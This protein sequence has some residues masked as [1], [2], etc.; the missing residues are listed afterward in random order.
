MGLL[1]QA[2]PLASPVK[3]MKGAMTMTGTIKS[4]AAS[5]ALISLA[6]GGAVKAAEQDMTVRARP[7]SA[8]SF[9][10]GS[11]HATGYFLVRDGSCD[12]SVWLADK[13]SGDE[14]AIGTPA[15]MTIPVSPGSTMFVSSAEGTAAEF[16]CAPNADFMSVRI[17]TEVA[18]SKPRP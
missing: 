9:D 8:I 5:A 4:I 2:Q 6:L 10:I 7:M 14:I 12:L 11:K 1:Q 17:L 15:R 16:A 3:S 13:S 18:Y